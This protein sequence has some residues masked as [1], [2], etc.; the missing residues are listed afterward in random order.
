MRQN[1]KID[2]QEEIP[3][4]N[5]LIYMIFL[6]FQDKSHYRNDYFPGNTE[7]DI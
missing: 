4:F 6:I 5:E 1:R 2:T 3:D 7:N